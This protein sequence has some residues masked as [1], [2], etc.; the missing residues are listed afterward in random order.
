M[1]AHDLKY[2][3]KRPNVFKDLRS[4]LLVWNITFQIELY[5]FFSV[6]FMSDVVYWSWS[7]II[8]QKSLW[9]F[10]V[11]HEILFYESE[12]IWIFSIEKGLESPISWMFRLFLC[13]Y[14][15]ISLPF[16]CNIHVRGSFC[17]I[18]FYSIFILM[19][20]WIFTDSL[21]FLLSETT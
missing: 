21:Q 16:F 18:P 19:S 1:L 17:H 13:K 9:I 3:I 7:S 12:F 8:F 4:Y 6:C 20:K 10:K 15:S 11:Q 2:G 14:G 5:I